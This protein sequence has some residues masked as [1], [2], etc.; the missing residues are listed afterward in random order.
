MRHE[1]S[2]TEVSAGP[3]SQP[4]IELTGLFTMMLGVWYP[5]HYVVAAIEPADGMAAA[6]ALRS[7]GFGERSVR[8]ETGA[9]VL[10]IRQQIAT[11]RT[12]LE[13]AAASITH[14]VTDEGFMSQQYFDEAGRGASLIAVL[15]PESQHLID[16]RQILVRHRARYIRYYGD[17]TIIDL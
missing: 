8:H 17:N 3:G 12:P 11:Q 2:G 6:Q 4:R 10:A 14:A 1:S 7:A 15:A 5:R 9:A 13:R 16:A